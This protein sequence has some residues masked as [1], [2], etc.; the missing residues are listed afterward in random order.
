MRSG[1][2]ILG[3]RYQ[4]G[5]GRVERARMPEVVKTGAMRSKLRKR[6]EKIWAAIRAASDW[7]NRYGGTAVASDCRRTSPERRSMLS[8]VLER[9]LSPKVGTSQHREVGVAFANFRQ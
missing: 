7:L 8:M 2:P 1:Q 9:M 6:P 5:G 3:A 4:S